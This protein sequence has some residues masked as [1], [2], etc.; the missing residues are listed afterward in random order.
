M[1]VQFATIYSIANKSGIV[2]GLHGLAIVQTHDEVNSNGNS[3]S[4]SSH[5]HFIY[6]LSLNYGPLHHRK[7]YN[8]R[9][10]LYA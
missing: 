6:T 5:K 2:K 8:Y 10:V 4:S 7:M 9:L 1:D 3:S